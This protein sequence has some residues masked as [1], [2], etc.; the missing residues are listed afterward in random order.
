MLGK[1]KAFT[2]AGELI[3][4]HPLQVKDMPSI[5]KMQKPETQAEGMKEIIKITL[6]KSIPEATDD[7]IDNISIAYL[8]K[9]MEAIIEVNNLGNIQ[10]PKNL[11][12]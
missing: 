3:E 11:N 4:V 5:V 12:K 1:P 9:L 6:K 2:I 8:E 10:I 7:E